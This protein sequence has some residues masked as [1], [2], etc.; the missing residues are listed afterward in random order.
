LAYLSQPKKRLP[1]HHVSPPNHHIYTTKTPRSN[2]YLSQ[3]PQQNT[4][5]PAEKII[6]N[7]HVFPGGA[8]F[9]PD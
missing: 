1:R 7:P 5:D 8:E 6:F 3:K 9:T 2:A 4:T